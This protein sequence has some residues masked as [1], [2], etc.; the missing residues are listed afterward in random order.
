MEAH[1]LDESHLQRSETMLTGV[2]ISPGLGMGK[3]WIA[4]DLLRLGA[5][6]RRIKPHEIEHELGRIQRAFGESQTELEESARRIEEQF[7]AAL[8]GIFRAH[9]MMLQSL[10]SLG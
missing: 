5:D 7:N 1:N 4:G 2:R 3:A 8:A 10:L 6:G 9:V